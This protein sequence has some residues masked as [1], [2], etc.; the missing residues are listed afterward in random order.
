M[1]RNF[2]P[3]RPGPVQSKRTARSPVLPRWIA[4]A[5]ACA[6]ILA[7]P[8]GVDAADS[9]AP[10]VLEEI[11][12]W[13]SRMLFDTQTSHAATK[14]ATPLRDLPVSAVL[15]GAEIIDT[16]QL[17]GPAPLL[18]NFSLAGSTPGERGLQEEILLRG[19]TDTPFY[20]NGISDSLGA[21]PVHDLANVASIE[22][23]KGPNSALYGP[24]EPG[25]AVNFV[26]KQPSMTPAG[27]LKTG[28]GED[29]R[30]RLEGDITGPLLADAGL[31]YRLVGAAES[32]DSFRDQVEAQQ[33]FI[34]PSLTWTP[35]AGLEVRA[36]LEFIRHVAP[37]DSG[38]VAV[39]GTFPLPAHTFLGE[40]ATG[41]T[42][43]EA[44][45]GTLE[46]DWQWRPSWSLA[47]AL[48]WQETWI[49]GLRAEPAELED[50]DLDE[51]AALLIRELV[52]EAENSRVFTGQAE[53]QGEFVTGVLQHRLLAGYEYDR[54]RDRTRV[55]I[56]DSDADPFAID[57]FHVAYGLAL[58]ALEPEED[59]REVI[60]QHGLY[61]QDFVTLGER[62]RLLLGTRFDRFDIDGVEHVAGATFDQSADDFSSRA[63]I[64]FHAFDAL[65]FFGSYSEAI[66]PNEG[67]LP[68]GEPLKPTRAESVE[69]GLRVRHPALGFALDVSVFRIEQ[70][71]VTTE[72]PD[73]PG[74]EVQTARQVSEGLDI[75]ASLRPLRLLQLGLAYA[76]TDAQ[77]RDDPE[78]PDG[79]TP[80]NVPLH[81]LVLYS[82][83]TASLL[84][85]GDVRAGLSLVYQSQRHASLDSGELAVKLDGYTTVNLFA[86][87]AL[88]PRVEFGLHVSNLLG[89]DY[90]AGS[91]GDLLRIAPGA[92]TTVYGT[93]TFRF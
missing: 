59:V 54:I 66:D 31:A 11:E 47:L 41:D 22:I 38:V 46:A 90:R 29:G 65:T 28:F 49:D 79:A 67:L 30:F 23:L 52:G 45:T 4:Q 10:P 62:W 3:H 35:D 69:A 16:T 50:I 24:G 6:A 19:F 7:L 32:V 20:R 17:T 43:I 80:I 14:V 86:S 12:V 5:L 87:F 40:P 93:L 36:A 44:L 53:L 48:N 15:I 26:T 42:R 73:D 18:D 56:S 78:V 89:A 74:F 51:P 72:A 61:L 84:R 13:G 88:S 57:P 25:G 68:S 39:D 63:G 58:P 83:A 77:V 64:V 85:E 75:E 71:N 2:R 33:R 8:P 37:F 81:K 70:T 82:L 91:Q 21:L 60:H 27:S 34:A 55:A 1:A 76:Y 9:T 92:P